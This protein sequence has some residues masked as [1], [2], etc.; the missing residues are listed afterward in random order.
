MKKLLKFICLNCGYIHY[1]D[2]IT[3]ELVDI[4]NLK[5][6]DYIIV[7]EKELGMWNCCI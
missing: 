4:K 5:D 3:N 1:K 2:L 7:A 6:D